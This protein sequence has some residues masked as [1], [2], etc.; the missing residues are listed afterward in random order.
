MSFTIGNHV[1]NSSR[2]VTIQISK[3]G[4]Y[5][6]YSTHV[7]PDDIGGLI[8]STLSNSGT[9]IVEQ[10]GTNI[11]LSVKGVPHAT[12]TYTGIN[13]YRFRFDLYTGTHPP[14]KVEVDILSIRTEGVEMEPP[15]GPKPPAPPIIN[16]V[17]F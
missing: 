3:E 1:G 9:F 16:D 13:F 5:Y 6:K 17:P 2:T 15:G 11:T 12:W 7:W 4:P 14:G 10:K 8:L